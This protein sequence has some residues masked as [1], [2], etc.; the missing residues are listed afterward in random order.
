MP[1][2]TSVLGATFS[3]AKTETDAGSGGSS[4]DKSRR[5]GFSYAQKLAEGT[6]FGGGINRLST[7]PDVGESDDDNLY[8]LGYGKIWGSVHKPEMAGEL[9]LHLYNEEGVKIKE[10]VSQ[11]VM[12]KGPIQY[13]GA[14]ALTI[15]EQSA[16]DIKALDLEGKMYYDFGGHYL[17]PKLGL[18]LGKI[19]PDGGD[20]TKERDTTAMTK[21]KSRHGARAII[22]GFKLLKL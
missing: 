20:A 15:N 17:A 5:I 9:V 10:I 7:T 19:D 11:G 12:N 4:T 16:G 14:A 1:G 21:Q 13:I 18:K 22:T 2:G 3:M 8:F 6:Y